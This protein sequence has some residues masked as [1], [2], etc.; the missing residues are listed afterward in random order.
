[1]TMRRSSKNIAPRMSGSRPRPE[2]GTPN[3]RCMSSNSMPS[4]RCFS[5]MSSMGIGGSITTPARLRIFGQQRRRIALDLFLLEVG[6]FLRHQV[7]ILSSASSKPWPTPSLV[8]YLLCL[9]GQPGD[10]IGRQALGGPQQRRQFD[11]VALDDVR[12]VGGH[13]PRPR[14]QDRRRRTR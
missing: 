6:H 8:L 12:D 9:P 1:M 10:V 5:T 11:R 14:Q 3:S 2:R 4:F 13:P 7:V